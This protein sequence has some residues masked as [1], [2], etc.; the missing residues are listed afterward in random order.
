MSDDDRATKQRITR[1]FNDVAGVFDRAGPRFFAHFGQRLV[2]RA[3][4][5]PGATIL[6]AACGRGAI[7][8]AAAQ[9]V[10]ARGHVVG[11]DLAHSMAWQAAA[12][13]DAAG[14]ENVTLCA[15]D[16]EHMALPEEYFDVVLCGF[17]IFYF[18]NLKRG[19]GEFR[20]VLKSSGRVG[21]SL[22]ADESPFNTW[23]MNRLQDHIPTG[24]WSHED[25]AGDDSDEGADP[26]P[27]FGTHEGLT[28][29]LSAAGF[30]KTRV[31]EETLEPVYDSPQQFLEM[32]W[33]CGTR[34]SLEAMNT[35][36]Y[37]TFKADL[38]A[39]LAAFR[40]AK[41]LHLPVFRVLLAFGEKT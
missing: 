38:F 30:S 26:P 14:L 5:P 10:G 2:D 18:P 11:F 21:V 25:E 28:A 3:A 39:Q 27:Q 15:M 31:Y 6:D 4:I 41:G 36:T 35:A 9:R 13:M 29:I 40:G 1:T 34:P 37:A 12:D 17:A 23:I 16:A 7:L 33:S 20:R 32:L 24:T 22:V 19:L 8:S